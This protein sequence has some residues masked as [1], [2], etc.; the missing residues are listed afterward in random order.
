MDAEKIVQE[1][2]AESIAVKQASADQLVTSIA[3]AGQLMSQSLLNDGKILS[4]GNGG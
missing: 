4:C 1:H 3:S 2:F